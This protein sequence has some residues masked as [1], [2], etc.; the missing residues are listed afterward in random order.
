MKRENRKA[1]DVRVELSDGTQK[2]LSDF[3]RQGRLVLVF[4][5]HFG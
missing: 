4:V 2:K 5:R 1:P 3:W